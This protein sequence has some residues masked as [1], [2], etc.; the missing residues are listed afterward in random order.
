MRTFSMRARGDEDGDRSGAARVQLLEQQRQHS[1]PRKRPR[2]VAYR[3]ADRSTARHKLTKWPSAGRY[4]KRG[5]DRGG[6]VGQ[7]RQ[8]P[9]FDNVGR[10]IELDAETISA[11]GQ[12]DALHITLYNA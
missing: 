2:H 9:R 8:V 1:A 10:G 5:A 4:P 7:V 6:L 3:D 11:V 12:V